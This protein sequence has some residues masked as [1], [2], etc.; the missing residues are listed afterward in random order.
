MSYADLPL[1][2]VIFDIVKKR[3]KITEKELINELKKS[4]QDYS[5]REIYRA[6]MI[7]ELFGKIVVASQKDGK[8]IMIKEHGG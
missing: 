4:S 8:I 1:E 3:Q 7:L 5:I 6:L 2:N